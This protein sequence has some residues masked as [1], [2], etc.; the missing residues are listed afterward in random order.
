MK[1]AMTNNLTELL[2]QREKLE[3]ERTQGQWEAIR[4]YELER[5]LSPYETNTI[6]YQG[7]QMNSAGGFIVHKDANPSHNSEYIAFCANYDKEII[8]GLRKR[9]KAAMS[10]AATNDAHRLCDHNDTL[11]FNE[12]LRSSERMV[13]ITIE[14]ICKYD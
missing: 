5:R 13:E 14:G 3:D 12:T 4:D 10:L 7:V 2:A 1:A 6:R 11:N 9:L 8:G